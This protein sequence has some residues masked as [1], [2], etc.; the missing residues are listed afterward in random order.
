MS[1]RITVIPCQKL[2]NLQSRGCRTLKEGISTDII[3]ALE[4]NF[5]EHSADDNP[6]SQQDIRF[7]SKGRY[8]AKRKMDT[9]NSHFVS[10]QT[11]LVS[12]ITNNVTRRRVIES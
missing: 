7:M 2:A 3:K 12:Q 11:N 1:A 6:V 10:S 9:F 5:I 4:L 8:K